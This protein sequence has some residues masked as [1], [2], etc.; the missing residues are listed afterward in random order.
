MFKY[1]PDK[2]RMRKQWIPGPFSSLN[3]PEG[4]GY[5]TNVMHTRTP[6]VDVD[7][8]GLV[9]VVDVGLVPIVGS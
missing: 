9:H 8:F 7:F 5:E 4:P 2:E 6:V 3:F 1:P